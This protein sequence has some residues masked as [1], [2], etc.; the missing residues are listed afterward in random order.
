VALAGAETLIPLAFFPGIAAVIAASGSPPA[1]SGLYYRL[2]WPPGLADSELDGGTEPRHRF[3]WA[4]LSE[5]NSVR[6]EP[7]GLVPV[8]QELGDDIHHV[9]L[10]RRDAQEG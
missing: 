4:A 2:A 10:D 3:R 8:L 9:L 5:L 7:A 6:F 1:R